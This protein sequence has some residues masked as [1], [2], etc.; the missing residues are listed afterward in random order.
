MGR[1]SGAAADVWVAPKAATPIAATAA[2][3]SHL[4]VPLRAFFLIS[5]M[6]HAPVV[7]TSRAGPDFRLPSNP[8]REAHAAETCLLIDA[9][10]RLA[11]SGPA[12]RVRNR[13]HGME[14]HGSRA[15]V[16]GPG[17]AVSRLGESEILRAP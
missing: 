8:R 7:K 13:P 12:F 10:D 2:K 1:L 17:D 9:F 6:S 5:S 15:G 3:D 11:G 14:R 4:A 16:T